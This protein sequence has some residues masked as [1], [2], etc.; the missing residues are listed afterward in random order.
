MRR[1]GARLALLASCLAGLLA[2]PPAAAGDTIKIGIYAGTKREWTR[3][4]VRGTFDLW[5]QELSTKFQIPVRI[6]HYD[7][8]LG[9]R[10]DFLAGDLDGVTADALTLARHFKTEEFTEG[11]ATL[12]KGGWN[13]MLFARRDGPPGGLDDL[14]GR[15]AVVLEHDQAGE[16]YLELLCMRQRQR[17]C[18]EVFSEIQRVGTSNQA[19]MRVFFGKADIAM[20]YGYGHETAVE[21]NPQLGQALRKLAERPMSSMFLAFYG[22][23]VDKAR[24]QQTLSVIPTLHTYP[25]G[26]QLLDIFKIDRLERAA[27]EE[28]RQ[29]VDLERE[30]REARAQVER[31]GKRR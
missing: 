12:M 8:P 1:R 31:K 3:A 24:R 21:M 9:M 2:S 4:E 30:Y 22:T 11:Y 15:K 10:G 16:M 17:P 14:Q 7:E 20:V 18:G 23:R 13:L 6:V 5:A 27:P 26:R 28:L 19:L 29:A 25:R